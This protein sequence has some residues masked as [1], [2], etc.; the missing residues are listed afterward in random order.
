[1]APPDGHELAALGQAMEPLGAVRD[2]AVVLQPPTSPR[3]ELPRHRLPSPLHRQHVQ[4]GR[5][6]LA[7]DDVGD[8]EPGLLRG[9][10]SGRLPGT[11]GH[12]GSTM[13]EGRSLCRR[14]GRQPPS[15]SPSRRPRTTMLHTSRSGASLSW[16]LVARTCSHR[17][18]GLRGVP[19]F[20][21]TAVEQDDGT[22]AKRRRTAF[23]GR[24]T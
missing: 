2:T 19:R 11:R 6:A 13:P 20:T 12:P 9:Q 23:G 22:E 8:G 5:L 4:P 15:P 3:P 14:R 1:M 18:T 24:P 21:A 17:V 10:L 7:F 16:I